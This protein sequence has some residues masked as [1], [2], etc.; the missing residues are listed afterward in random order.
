MR[1]VD[2]D[3]SQCK[4]TSHNR[5]VIALVT[6]FGILLQFGQFCYLMVSI[7]HKITFHVSQYFWWY[8]NQRDVLSRLSSSLTFFMQFVYKTICSSQFALTTCKATLIKL[9]IMNCKKC[10]GFGGSWCKARVGTFRRSKV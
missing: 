6:I 8:L 7:S 4:I 5:G 1:V 3:I 9:P 2:D 10:I